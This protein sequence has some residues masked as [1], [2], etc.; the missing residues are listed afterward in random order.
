MGACHI[1]VRKI[2][3]G[4]YPGVGA[5]RSSGQNGYLGAYPGVGAFPGDYGNANVVTRHLDTIG[6]TDL[7]A[8]GI[9]SGLEK[10]LEKYRLP[11]SK[12]ISFTSDY[13]GSKRWGNF[14]V[15][16]QTSSAATVH[17]ILGESERLLKTVLSFYID[18]K[19]VRLNSSDITKVNYTD[20]SNYLPG[21]KVFVGDNTTAL[22][23]HLRDNEGEQ[24]HVVYEKVVNFY[25]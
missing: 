9:F 16:F 20:S 4:A 17:K 11:F 6:I 23:T 19:V 25:E 5:F 3:L 24:V 21:D 12:L 18:P 14:N 8:E 13:E 2:Y 7:S 1:I 15:F 10:T 22:L